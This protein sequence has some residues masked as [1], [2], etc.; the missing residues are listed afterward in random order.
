MSHTDVG[1]ISVSNTTIDV[2][3]SVAV[4]NVTCNFVTMLQV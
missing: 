4:F 2:A 1:E 3:L